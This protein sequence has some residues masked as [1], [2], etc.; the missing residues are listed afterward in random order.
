M[1]TLARFLSEGQTSRPVIDETR[2]AGN[3]DFRL[4]WTS[5]PSLNPLQ[6]ASQTPPSD[7]GISVFTALQQQLGLKLEPRASSADALVVKRA[8]LPSAN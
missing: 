3:F 5:D 1:P 2:M 8:G 6:D 7:V 4:K